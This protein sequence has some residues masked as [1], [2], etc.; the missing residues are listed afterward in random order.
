MNGIKIY[1]SFPWLASVLTLLASLSLSTGANAQRIPLACQT[2]EVGGLQW[3]SGRWVASTFNSQKFVLI[4]EGETLTTESAVK[5]LGGNRATCKATLIG[6]ISCEDS[7]GGYLYFSPKTKAGTIAQL[8]GGA[9][10]NMN[11]GNKPDSLTIGPFVCQA[12]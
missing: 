10:G 12:F 8:T 7:F 11:K 1:R 5:A 4:Q 6:L 3:Q 9:M 2:E